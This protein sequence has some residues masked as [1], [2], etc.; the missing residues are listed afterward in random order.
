MTG[1]IFSAH[2]LF[3]ATKFAR[4][5]PWQL[6]TSVDFQ[7]V[8]SG[9]IIFCHYYLLRCH[10]RMIPI[11]SIH[12]HFQSDHSES[13]CL[14]CPAFCPNSHGEKATRE[15]SL[16]SKQFPKCPSVSGVTRRPP[17]Y[18]A[19]AERILIRR[20][21]AVQTENHS[22]ISRKVILPFLA[23]LPNLQLRFCTPF[24]LIFKKN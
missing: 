24:Q 2:V 7:M 14:R 13:F 22:Y 20:C 5:N 10:L 9:P 18:K 19:P 4:E 17:V 21:N 1:F 8:N 12:C 3:V 6:A 15:P 16:A 11:P 23:Q